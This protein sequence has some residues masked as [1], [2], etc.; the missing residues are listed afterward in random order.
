MKRST[1]ILSALIS[2]VCI[3]LNSCSKSLPNGDATVEKQLDGTWECVYH[4]TGYE[5]GE[6][7]DMKTVDKITYDS[8]THKLKGTM[9]LYMKSPV[10]MHMVT[11]TYKGEW[12]A[13]KETL[14][15]RYD[16]NSVKFKFHTGLLNK[17]D[18][19]EMK[20]ELLNDLSEDNNS[21]IRKLSESEIVLY[22]GEDDFTYTRK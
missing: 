14:T 3:S 18:K 22:D 12:S 15:E 17:S 11:V 7:F 8:K 1:I 6:Y 10:K 20:E 2:L 21:E 13:D 9:D 4:E 5:D 19:E 16:K